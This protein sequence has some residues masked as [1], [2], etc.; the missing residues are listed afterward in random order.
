MVTKE[1]LISDIILQLTQGNPSDDIAVEEDQVAFWLQ[2]HLHDLIRREIIDY[3]KKGQQ[4][5]PIYIRR[6]V[7]LALGEEAIADV[8]D[9]NQ[10]LYVELEE[11][12]LDLPRDGGVIRVLDYDRNLIHMTAAEDLE[13]LRNSRF[14]KPSIDNVIGYREG[15]KIFIEGFNTADIDFNP[16][17]V[18]YI[19]KQDVIAMADDDEVLVSDQLV[20]VLIDLCVQRGKLQ[21]YGTVPD[22]ANDGTDA[23]QPVYHTSIQNPTKQDAQPTEE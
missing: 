14:A 2:Y 18:S 9:A 16:L 5:P 13:D 8:A 20:P 4:I 6:D 3:R 11:D 1:Q 17:M 23:K 21:M 15:K 10:R 7:A 22:Q 19:P 12:V